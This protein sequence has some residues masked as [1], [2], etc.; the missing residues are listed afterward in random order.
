MIEV[1]GLLTDSCEFIGKPDE[2][3]KTPIENGL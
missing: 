2:S 1:L 3:L